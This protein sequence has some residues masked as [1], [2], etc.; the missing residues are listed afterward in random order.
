MLETAPRAGAAGFRAAAGTDPGRVRAGNE[1]RL[2]VD[3]DRGIFLVVDGV[4]GHA[5]GEVAAGIAIQVIAQRLERPPLSPEPRVVREAIALANNEIFSQAQVSPEHAGMTC[6]LTLALLTERGL[7]I[8]HVGDTRLYRITPAGM[9]KITHDHSPIG[10]REDA[11]EITEVEAMRHPRRNEV[12]RDVGS[13]FHEPEDADFI[14]LIEEPFDARSAILLCSD[15]LSDMVSSASIERTI[16]QHAGDPARVV[17]ALILAANEAGGKDN[18]TVVYV[19]GDGFARGARAATSEPAPSSMTREPVDAREGGGFWRSR[20]TWLSLGL[21]AG[22]MS[23]LLLAWALTLYAPVSTTAGRTLVV[24]G[25]VA[26]TSTSE[27]PSFASIAGAMA[28]ASSRDTVQVEPGVYEEAVVLRDGVN[29]V[30]RVP[31]SVTLTAPPA[32]VGWVSIS[33][34]GRLGNRISGVKVQGRPDARIAVGLRL[35][36]HDLQVDDVT[37][38]GAVGVGMDVVNDGMVVVRASRFS[39]IDGMPI[40]IG[41]G[42]R[43]VV[44]QNLFLHG[45]GTGTPIEIAS[46]A[47]PDIRGNLFAGYSALQAPAPRHPLVEGNYVITTSERAPAPRRRTQ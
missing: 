20:A 35:A 28:A 41:P 25:D 42:A 31:G 43:P 5:A 11:R 4:G 44:R 16:R 12:F 36:G 6:V 45:G 8:G 15:G 37:V 19:E 13:I 39:E 1:D 7:T 21:L 17:E 3:A 18:I 26:T 40:R 23:G 46:G 22:V 30:A 34:D 32:S 24:N 29:L 38:E 47:S 33:A 10:E 14:E 2:H 9:V 27:E